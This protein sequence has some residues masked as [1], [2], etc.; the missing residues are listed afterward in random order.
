MAGSPRSQKVTKN[1]GLVPHR[2]SLVHERPFSER[3]LACSCSLV[4]SVEPVLKKGRGK[5]PR[6]VLGSTSI[7]RVQGTSVGALS[8]NGEKKNPIIQCNN[9][10][11]EYEVSRNA[12]IKSVNISNKETV[13]EM[14]P[15]SKER[16]LRIG[17]EAR[18]STVGDLFQHLQAA[19]VVIEQNVSQSRNRSSNITRHVLDCYRDVLRHHFLASPYTRWLA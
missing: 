10:A 2:D 4:P 7:S 3:V 8:T 9:V 1:K 5:I 13:P 14:D 11:I 6:S 16:W 12:L 17:P 15:P 18:V 19:S